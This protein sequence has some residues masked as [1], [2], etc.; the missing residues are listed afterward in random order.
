MFPFE[1]LYFCLSTPSCL[2]PP[3]HSLLPLHLLPSFPFL[4]LLQRP[5]LNLSMREIRGLTVN[6]LKGIMTQ[7]SS[8][9]PPPAGQATSAS[10]PPPSSSSSS[11]S[12]APANTAA[13]ASEPL[14]PNYRATTLMPFK[15]L[16]PLTSSSSSSSS[17]PTFFFVHPVEGDVSSL[18]P[19]ASALPFTS[20]GLQVIVLFVCL[21][22]LY[23][24]RL[25]T[26]LSK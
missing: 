4:V 11:S 17:S 15:K 3:P 25:S 1:T 18:T 10:S 22:L 23:I 21:F 24:L 26:M 7:E 16:V 5:Q 9:T 13:T 2:L 12:S 8:S 19:L 14:G 20:F 6:K